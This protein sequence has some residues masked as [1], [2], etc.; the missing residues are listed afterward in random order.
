MPSKKKVSKQTARKKKVVKKKSKKKSAS[1]KKAQKAKVIKL[2]T[3]Q[4]LFVREYLI[5]LNATQ[6]AIRA[7]YSE[8]TAG[9]IG[10]ENL[11]KP[12]IATAIIEQMGKREERVEIDADYVLNQ[13]VKL[14]E[15]CM[16]EIEPFTDKKGN[17][18][19]DDN[20]KAIYLFNAAGAA[21][22]LELV[23]KHVNVQAFR[24]QL[25]V[26]GPK[27]EPLDTTWVVQVMQ[28]KK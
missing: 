19:Y 12:E 28:A 9:A 5:D 10:H 11:K 13:G 27:G 16:Q 24:D 26:G 7:G 14:H 22:A 15:R 8:K 3:K 23:G 1:G 25:G 18:I 6:A 21:K 17:Q 20:G 4:R 2:T